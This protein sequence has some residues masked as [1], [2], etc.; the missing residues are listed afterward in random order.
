PPDPVKVSGIVRE[1][2]SRQGDFGVGTGT[3]EEAEAAGREWLGPKARPSSDGRALVSEDGLRIYRPPSYKSGLGKTQAN[4]E[5]KLPGVN[6]AVSN[7]H[8]DIIEP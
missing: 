7:A 8:L 1:A 4:F 6:K 5:R 3:R 2:A